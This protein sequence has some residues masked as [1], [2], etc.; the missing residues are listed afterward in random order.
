MET[1]HATS[2][3]V[4]GDIRLIGTAWLLD[5]EKH[6]D[7]NIS[8]GGWIQGADWKRRGDGHVLQEHRARDT[9]GGHRHAAGRWRLGHQSRA[10]WLPQNHRATPWSCIRL[11]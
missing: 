7:G 6:K 2:A 10:D 9:P 1:R 3:A 11:L 5:T 4:L 8:L